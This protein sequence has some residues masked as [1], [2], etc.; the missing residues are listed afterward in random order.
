[1]QRVHMEI[2]FVYNTRFTFPFSLIFKSFSK[3]KNCTLHTDPE[4]DD[5]KKIKNSHK[6]KSKSSK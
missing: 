2:H 1:M 5:I 4:Y 6:T 3:R